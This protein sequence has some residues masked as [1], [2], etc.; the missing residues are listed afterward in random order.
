VLNR[1]PTTHFECPTERFHP[2]LF[3]PVFCVMN[4]DSGCAHGMPSDLVTSTSRG[5]AR[6]VLYS[7]LDDPDIQ[8]L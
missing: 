4:P 6:V 3:D 1:R 7:I 8:Q 2:L 5:V